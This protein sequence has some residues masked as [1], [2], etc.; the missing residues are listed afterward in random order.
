M[1]LKKEKLLKLPHI[2]GLVLG[3]SMVISSL[4]LMFLLPQKGEEVLTEKTSKPSS[5]N[6]LI[7][8]EKLPVPKEES[9]IEEKKEIVLKESGWIP[10]WAFDL[11]FES[12][13]NNKGIIG[14]V[15][16][17]L[18]TVDPNG[19]IVSRGVPEAS[20]VELV[21][22]SIKNSIKVI[23]TI[24]S[25]DFDAM[26]IVF[27]S[28]DSYTGHINT[29]I[30]E[31]DKYGFDGIDIDYE[32]I[33]VEQKEFFLNFL[34]NLKQEL[35]QRNK[36]LSIS[37]FP[38][39]ENAQYNE[40]QETREVQEYSIIGEIA[41]EIRIMAYDYT[42]QS[43]KEPGPIAPLNW[44]KDILDY[45]TKKIPPEKIWL[46]VNLYGYQ[47]SS[48]RTVAFTYTTAKNSIIDS[49]SI[50]HTYNM[51]TGEGYAEFGCDN[52]FLC[53]AYFQLP[54]GIKLRRE[55]A[56]EYEIAGVAYWRL[57]GELNILK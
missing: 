33:K 6:G 36:I 46:G 29:I 55:I 52:G 13:K 31:M 41:D 49:P 53:K 51:D 18:Y 30:S 42:V 57:G 27:A 40:S 39:W 48:D 25:F 22:Y 12:L 8:R 54:E 44:V 34:K 19:N 20:I 45:A 5:I 9:K 17:V 32:M 21:E 28:N 26:S 35:K 47:W 4:L 38:Q 1:T 14:T 43:S 2:L 15:N 16:P 37:V 3:S 24:G 11:G 56:K 50:N 7:T 23:P 10:N